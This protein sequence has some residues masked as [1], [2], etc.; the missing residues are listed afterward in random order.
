MI[1]I[2]TCRGGDPRDE[3]CFGTGK[4]A[5][6]VIK[7]RKSKNTSIVEVKKTNICSFRSYISTSAARTLL[8]L[9]LDGKGIQ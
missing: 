5:G 4:T 7:Q 8:Y 2:P 6:V 9:D 3:R 1:L